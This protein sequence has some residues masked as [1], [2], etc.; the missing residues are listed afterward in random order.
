[1]YVQLKEDDLINLLHGCPPKRTAFKSLANYGEGTKIG[2]TWDEAK[3][4]RLTEN[5]LYKIYITCKRSWK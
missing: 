4:K 2:W 1:M 5:E 3:L